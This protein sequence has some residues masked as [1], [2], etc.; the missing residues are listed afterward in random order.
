MNISIIFASL[1]Y[2]QLL[3]IPSFFYHRKK[4]MN[5]HIS[6]HLSSKFH[7]WDIPGCTQTS[8]TA[9]LRGSARSWLSLLARSC[10]HPGKSSARYCVHPHPMRNI[11]KWWVKKIQWKS[12]ILC[13]PLLFSKVRLWKIK[14]NYKNIW[15]CQILCTPWKVSELKLLSG[16]LIILKVNNMD[17]SLG[18]ICAVSITATAA[19]IGAAGIPQ[20]QSV[21]GSL[22]IIYIP[23]SYVQSLDP[24]I[25]LT[26]S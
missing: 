21:P 4:S 10:G 23:A 25:S 1:I 7:V 20:V 13:T 16:V 15:Q 2:Y 6:F 24:T 9:W 14:H 8:S 17:L 12:E 3:L 19:S 11:C 22:N 5:Y 26:D 18:Q